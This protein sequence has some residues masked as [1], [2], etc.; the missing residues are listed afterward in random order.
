MVDLI[1]L[2]LAYFVRPGLGL[3]AIYLAVVNACVHVVSGMVQRAYN[4][5][6]VTALVLLLPAGSVG[7]WVM[8]QAQQATASDHMWGFG[9]ALAIH[10]FIA[11]H[12]FRRVRLL[13]GSK[14]S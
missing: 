4:P 9:T 2:Y 1:S 5:G 6:L 13:R 7:L 3:I 12:I 11:I 14:N 8:R 10:V